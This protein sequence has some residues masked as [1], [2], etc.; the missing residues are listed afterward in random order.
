MMQRFLLVMVFLIL[1]LTMSS[2]ET[3]QKFKLKTTF[4]ALS[5]V[6]F[7][8]NKLEY[9]QQIVG[10]FYQTSLN[11]WWI[12]VKLGLDYRSS[13][14]PYRDWYFVDTGNQKVSFLSGQSF[15]KNINLFPIY[16]FNIQRKIGDRFT[17]YIKRNG[18]RLLSNK[19]YSVINSYQTIAYPQLGY[20]FKMHKNLRYDFSVSNTS[21]VQFK[22]FASSK[23]I[24]QH[25]LTFKKEKKSKL[26]FSLF[27]MVVWKQRSEVGTRFVDPMYLIPFNVWRPV[28][29]ASG[30]SDNVILGYKVKYDLIEKEN[31][32]L[33]LSHELLL[34][35]F[36]YA[37]IKAGNGWWANKHG[38]SFAAEMGY[39][40][41]NRNK[42]DVT[43]AYAH[44]R[45]YTYSH[46]DPTQ[47][48]SSGIF[49]MA[50]VLG[51]NYREIYLGAR[52]LKQL[53]KINNSDIA[54]HLDTYIFARFV[55]QGQD[56][57]GLN[58]GNDVVVSNTSRINDYGNFIGQPNES[59]Y[60][61]WQLITYWQ[62]WEKHQIGAWVYGKANDVIV[63][64]QYK[65]GL[66]K[67]ISSP[68]TTGAGF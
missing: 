46:S 53:K 42:F 11:K 32:Q 23:W 36:L 3:K 51:S 47:S 15:N 68:N 62:N 45:P 56:L 33:T 6:A 48:Y 12:N 7:F 55:T 27:E 57:N 58:F 17:V 25:S 28:E 18:N 5:E 31:L 43:V 54:K 14:L 49:S 34:D 37:E 44:A 39:E 66:P 29:F 60:L 22:G 1:R 59:K 24:A 52:W 40:L 38:L 35:E 21:D 13:S 61:E 20:W 16:Y 64:L 10:N 65:V 41:N 8:N 2:Q 30:S 63:G 9:R 4:D 19:S 26:E 67:A 50:N